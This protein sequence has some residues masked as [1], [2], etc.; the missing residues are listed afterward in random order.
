M[1]AAGLR[2]LFRYHRQTTSI[3]LANPHRFRHTF[4]LRHDPRRYESSCA[5]AADGS[6][7]HPDHAAYVLVTPQDVYLEYARAVAQHIRPLPKA[8]S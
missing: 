4:C 3:N 5:H 1:T 2:S 8:S 6:R 7:G